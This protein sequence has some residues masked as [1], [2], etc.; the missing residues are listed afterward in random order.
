MDGTP[1]IFKYFKTNKNYLALW[2][3]GLPSK[4][5]V[6]AAVFSPVPINLCLY[7]FLSKNPS[8]LDFLQYYYVLVQGFNL[9]GLFTGQFNTEDYVAH[10]LY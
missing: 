9:T 2:T 7:Y 3:G 6:F 5:Q 1:K 4:A 8:A 10:L